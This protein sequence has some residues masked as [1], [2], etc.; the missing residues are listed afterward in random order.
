MGIADGKGDHSL[1]EIFNEEV[2]AKPKRLEEANHWKG[3]VGL[4]CGRG[5]EHSKIKALWVQ[6]LKEK[7]VWKGQ[8]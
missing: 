8:E 7:L 2:T 4:G 3:R 5:E 6:E 1:K